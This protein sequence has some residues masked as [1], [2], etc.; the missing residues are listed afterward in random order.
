MCVF[1]KSEGEEAEQ[2]SASRRK[3]QAPGIDDESVVLSSSP[4]I[5]FNPMCSG[6][7][8][9]HRPPSSS[10]SPPLPRSIHLSFSPLQPHLNLT[11]LSPSTTSLSWKSPLQLDSTA[12][13]VGIRMSA[14]RQSQRAIVAAPSDHCFWQCG[15]SVLASSQVVSDEPSSHPDLVVTRKPSCEAEQTREPTPSAP[16]PHTILQVTSATRLDGGKRRNAHERPPAIS[17]CHC[18]GTF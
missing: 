14:H 11:L 3:A 5:Q 9:T 17:A 15:R 18:G 12:A 1:D 6:P 10:K 7:G 8:R 4:S 13:S 2:N 16:L